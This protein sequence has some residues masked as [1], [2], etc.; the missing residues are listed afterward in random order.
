ML[1]KNVNLQ[2]L[3]T[4]ATRA[5][6]SKFLK[7]ES[8]KQLLDLKEI[9]NKEKVLILGGGSN[10]FF[11]KNFNGLVI[12]NQLKGKK[13]IKENNKNIYVSI[14]AGENWHQFIKW[15]VKNNYYGLENLAY[16][17]GLVGASPIQNI[18]AYGVEV[19]NFISVVKYFDFED[20]KTKYITQNEC[21]FGYRD[22]IFKQELANK[23]CILEV[24]F[25]L[26]KEFQPIIEYKDLEE[27]LKL[28][29]IAKPTATDIFE[30]I[31]EIRQN[32]LPDPHFLPN[33]GSFFKNCI[34][35]IEKYQKLKQKYPNLPNYKIDDKNVKI[36]TAWLLDYLH[37]K[38][39]KD[40]K[41]QIMLF[42]KQPLVL[43]NY[44]KKSG[45]NIL[46]FVENVTKLI[47]QEF[48]I[49]LEIE[50]NIY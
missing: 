48:D 37:L 26:N 16:I 13:I 20:F 1:L 17:P 43:V 8:K 2:P 32:K 4:M 39:K 21:N 18:G 19:K 28:K 45:K 29:N 9:I 5:I 27:N 41:R 31:I 30:N 11:T 49:E 35:S 12:N 7:L 22:S 34:I 46:E 40:K 3:H 14:K 47:K 33:S 42:E 24:T 6:A 44:G 25:V 36:P 50:V 10:L 23:I 15:C 38:G